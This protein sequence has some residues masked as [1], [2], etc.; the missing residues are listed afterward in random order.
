[1]ADGAV[2]SN[3]LRRLEVEK[4]GC[5]MKLENKKYFGCERYTHMLA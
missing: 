3:K 2:P 4:Y 5:R 1:M